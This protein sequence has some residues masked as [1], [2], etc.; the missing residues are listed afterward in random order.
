VSAGQSRP[1]AQLA[2]GIS[3]V[4]GE[5]FGNQ[6]NSVGRLQIAP[7]EFG[8][9]PR[10]AGVMLSAADDGVP[11]FD[12]RHYRTMEKPSYVRNIG[13]SAHIDSA[14]TTLTSGSCTTRP[15]PRHQE[16]VAEGRW[17]DHWSGEGT[18][19]HDHLGPLDRPVER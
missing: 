5:N 17:M 8:K 19:D 4:V 18:R 12:T 9:L 14:K 7:H 1:P 15:D 16:S 13:I 6:L 10:L 11:P 2:D 3:C